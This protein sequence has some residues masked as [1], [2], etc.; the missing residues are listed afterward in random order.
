MNYV[1]Y[2]SADQLNDTIR[3]YQF[4]STSDQAMR[5]LFSVCVKRAENTLQQNIII[6][7]GLKSL[8]ILHCMKLLCVICLSLLYFALLTHRSEL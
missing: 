3:E 5:M 4:S 8:L 1:E 2:L 7:F 6:I